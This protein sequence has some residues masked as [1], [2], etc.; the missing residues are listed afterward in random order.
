MKITPLRDKIF[1]EILDVGEI[2]TPGGVILQNDMGKENRPRWF[3]VEAVGP[4][5]TEVKEGDYALVNSG[6]WSTLL[7]RRSDGVELRDIE[8]D[9]ILAVAD[10]D[11]MSSELQQ[12][13]LKK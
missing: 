11:N 1:A 10:K 6:R 9:G 7:K 8:Y 4:D 5:A 13:L 2:T 3:K 12:L